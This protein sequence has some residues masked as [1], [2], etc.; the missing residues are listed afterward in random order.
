MK[1]IG[2]GLITTLLAVIL[3]AGSFAN[4]A[5]APRYTLEADALNELGLF[6]GSDKG[7]ELE[8]APTRTEAIVLLIRLLGKEAEAEACTYENPFEDIPAWADRHVAWAYTEGLAKGYSDTS[9][10]AGENADAKMFIT[11][12]LRA[13]G[14][15]DDA[16]DFS[17]EKAPVKAEEIGLISSGVYADGSDFYR[18]D[19]VH[20]CY[21]A[22]MNRINGSESTLAEKLAGEGAI[23]LQTARKLGLVPEY[24]GDT[25]ELTVACV[26]DSLTFGM[27]TG[28]P[29]TE[30]YP[31]VL[32]T[33]TG[34]FKFTTENYGYSGATV[35]YESFLAY[36]NTQPYEDSL[37][38]EADIVLIMLGTNDAVWSPNQ[39]DFPEDFRQMLETY[40]NLPHSP[41]VIVMTPPHLLG[42]EGFD[43]LLADV[44]EEEKSVIS[45]MGLD[46]INVYEFTENMAKYSEDGI[47][48]T[49]EG[50]KILAE[51]IYNELCAVLSE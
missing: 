36:A 37:K 50:Y 25:K 39:P 49:A 27:G 10:G 6:M 5:Y 11:F 8:R 24:T 33:F 26:G 15:D 47:H 1:K 22:L 29:D 46:I 31:G 45:E 13:L 17:Y 21:R 14:Y 42:I 19:C 44:V 9:F 48:F 18:D 30:S 28:N 12:V 38:T 4:A 40:I 23:S 51:Y 41:R 43:D 35:D 32:A 3:I 20:I 7:Y 2:T 16:G 34:E